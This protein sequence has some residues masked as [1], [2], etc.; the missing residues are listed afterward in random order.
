MAFDDIIGIFS[1]GMGNDF[2]KLLALILY[3]VYIFASNVRF[4]I[5]NEQK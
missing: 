5:S 4:S 2:K 3:D 1:G